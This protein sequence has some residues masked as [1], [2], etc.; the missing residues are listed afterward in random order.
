MTNI[1][2]ILSTAQFLISLLDVKQ[3]L[4]TG[5]KHSNT[6]FLSEENH[7]DQLSRSSLSSVAV[8]RYLPRLCKPL[9]K[10]RLRNDRHVEEVL[11]FR[12]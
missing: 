5:T 12:T 8:G 7:K 10:A 1:N 6:H 2:F 11:Y 4:L 9:A 3:Q